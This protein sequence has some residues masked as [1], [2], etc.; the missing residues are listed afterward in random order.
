LPQIK[1]LEKQYLDTDILVIGSGVT[2]C[3]AAIQAAER[4]LNVVMISK[5]LAGKGGCSRIA[6]NLAGGPPHIFLSLEER[7]RLAKAR[8][9]VKSEPDKS[10]TDKQKALLSNYCAYFG[11]WLNDQDF[12]LDAGAWVNRHFYNWFEEHGL[13]MRRMPDGS[14]ITSKG[15][16]QKQTWAPRQG[17]TGPQL[18]DLLR[19]EVFARDNIRVI[20]E[21][22]VT[23]LLTDNGAVTGGIGLGMRDSKLYVISAKAT[24]LCTGQAARITTRTT[25]TREVFGE[26]YVAAFDAGAEL[27][28]LE[29]WYIHVVD[30]KDPITLNQHCYPNPNPNTDKTPH[31]FN[32]Y[33][34]FYFTP[35]QFTQGT[36]AMYHLQ[37]KRTIQQIMQGKAK[38]DG[39][40]YSSYQHMAGEFDRE[41]QAARRVFDHLGH[42]NVGED[43]IENAMNF[44]ANFVGGIRVDKKTM[45][46][47]IPGLYAPGGAGGHS[48]FV[49]CCYCAQV[50]VTNAEGRAKEVRIPEHIPAQ[51]TGEEFRLLGLLRAGAKD[52]YHPGIV[53]TKVRQIMTEAL[54]PWKNARKL[55]KN[56]EELKK[57]QEVILPQMALASLSLNYNQGWID[58]IDVDAMLKFSELLLLSSLERTESRGPY[59]RDDYPYT[60]NENW[61]AHNVLGKVDGRPKFRRV[62]VDMKYVRPKEEGR[63]DYFKVV[64]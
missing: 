26:G 42:M 53:M 14:L 43:M 17:Q 62:P 13:Y 4:G 31:I 35:D 7:Q 5:S 56:L 27:E 12:A 46:T 20:E 63:A 36:T 49:H 29:L 41:Y 34:E 16:S 11:H 55:H 28:D 51:V 38:W 15:Q 1:E 21:C 48:S 40:Y 9:E 19:H 25:A 30:N 58:A 47:R 18:M 32:S 59:F 3:F 60:D 52:S 61:L 44:E 23:R 22:M 57:M 10:S 2:G 37:Y 45:Q 39:G 8:K 33:G 6:T 50:S 64:Y 54:F 24:L